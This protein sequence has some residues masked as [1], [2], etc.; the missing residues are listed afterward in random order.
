[1]RFPIS[2]ARTLHPSPFVVL[3]GPYHC[4]YHAHTA[5]RVS[6]FLSLYM[7]TLCRHARGDGCCSAGVGPASYWDQQSWKDAQVLGGDADDDDDG[8]DGDDDDDDD[9]DDDG[10]DDDDN[11]N[12]KKPN[13]II[14][15]TM[16]VHK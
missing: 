9:D 6:S 4:A 2:R 8:D 15:L 1:M 7:L 3:S 16:D 14:I 11:N 12:N 5:T 10:D 13:F